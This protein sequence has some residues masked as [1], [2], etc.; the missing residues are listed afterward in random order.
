MTSRSKMR[1]YFKPFPDKLV[2]KYLKLCRL[3]IVPKGKGTSSV[4]P[5]IYTVEGGGGGN[6]KMQYYKY[7]I[8]PMKESVKNSTVK[9]SLASW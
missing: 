8:K 3:K 7:K 9:Y 5:K 4:K 2:A 6:L 1:L